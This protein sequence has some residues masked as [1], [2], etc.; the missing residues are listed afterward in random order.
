MINP[1]RQVF[2]G[3]SQDSFL[4]GASVNIGGENSH[5]LGI[6]SISKIIPNTRKVCHR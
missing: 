4:G 2:R 1:D 6:G 3:L 5:Y